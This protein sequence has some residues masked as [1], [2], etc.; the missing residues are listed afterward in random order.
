MILHVFITGCT[1]SCARAV[2]QAA[3]AP[4]PSVRRYTLIRYR[5][6]EADAPPTTTT[7]HLLTHRGHTTLTKCAR[8]EAR[9]S[10]SSSSYPS[11]SPPS[12]A[13]SAASHPA[14]AARATP[15]AA[16]TR[17]AR[18]GASS[19]RALQRSPPATRRASP[20][21]G[22]PSSSRARL[23]KCAATAARGGLTRRRCS[24]RSSRAANYLA[25]W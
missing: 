18:W 6:T 7:T 8:V 21:R 12:R 15:P 2:S 23:F 19:A 9:P 3:M 5:P 24:P 11:P 25:L 4:S 14:T 10:S 16:S 17:P 13:S 1:G 22:A 20:Q